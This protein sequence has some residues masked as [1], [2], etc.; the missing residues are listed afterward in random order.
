MRTLN[1]DAMKI[2]LDFQNMQY[3]AVPDKVK[4]NPRQVIVAVIQRGHGKQ[5]QKACQAILET[6]KT[7]R[8]S[9]S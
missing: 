7:T 4:P 1:V 8:I 6:L 9:W 2:L 3:A 5:N